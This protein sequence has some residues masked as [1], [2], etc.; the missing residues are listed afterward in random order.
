MAAITE[1]ILSGWLWNNQDILF[2]LVWTSFLSLFSP[3]ADTHQVNIKE[4]AAMKTARCSPLPAS[5]GSEMALEHSRKATGF[6]Q[7]ACMFCTCVGR[8]NSPNQLVEIVCIHWLQ[9][10]NKKFAYHF[11]ILLLTTDSV[12]F[13]CH[14]KNIMFKRWDQIKIIILILFKC[15]RMLYLGSFL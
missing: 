14:R 7:L 10:V 12:S 2:K 9:T 8:N 5:S 4:G 13:L 3:W 11:H 1:H 15:N 6:S